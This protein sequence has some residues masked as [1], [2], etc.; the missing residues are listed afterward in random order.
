M[1]PRNTQ[2]LTAYAA[3]KLICEDSHASGAHEML[4]PQ[5]AP[6]IACAYHVPDMTSDALAQRPLHRLN[7]GVL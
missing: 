1:S 2:R 7:V 5:R 3:G 6:V 4:F